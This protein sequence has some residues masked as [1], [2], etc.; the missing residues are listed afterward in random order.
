MTI[1]LHCPWRRS[2]RR[3]DR[4]SSSALFPYTSRCPAVADTA[5]HE[6]EKTRKMAR[7]VQNGRAPGEGLGMFLLARTES[8]FPA[9]AGS[10]CTPQ[11]RGARGRFASSQVLPPFLHRRSS[12]EGCGRDP[13]EA[14]WRGGSPLPAGAGQPVDQL[15]DGA[16]RHGGSRFSW[17]LPLEGSH[18]A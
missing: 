2:C 11:R 16:R 15:Q 13:W 5:V 8:R 12:E 3:G 17:L 9:A 6:S 18:R 10:A 7:R 4:Y 1:P 14:R